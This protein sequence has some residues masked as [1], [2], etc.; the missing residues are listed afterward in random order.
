MTADVRQEWWG[1]LRHGGMLLAPALLE[2]TV[3][4][5]DPLD[6]RD[7]ERLRLAW[8]R[9]TAAAGEPSAD[10]EF[11][12]ALLESFLDLRD[13]WQKASTV[14]PAFKALATNGSALRPDWVLT[15][16][17]TQD[18]ALVLVKFDP[19][20]RLGIGRSRRAHAALVELLRATGAP[21]GLLTNGHQLRLVHA[22]P[23]YDAWAEW[24]ARRWFD[25]TEGRA[26]LQGLRA[27]IGTADRLTALIAAIRDSRSRQGELAQVLGEQV[28]QGVELVLTAADTHADPPQIIALETDPATGEALEEDEVLAALYQAGTRVVMRLV[29]V[30]YAEARELL[31][32]GNE[33]YH[34][35]YGIESLYRTLSEAARDG[36]D[37]SESRTAWRRVLSLFRLV[38]DGSPHPDLPVLAYGGQ[39]FRPGDLTS[40]DPIDR[41][42]AVVERAPV[43]DRT[44]L[45]VL[46]LLKVGRIRVRR[47]RS[48]TWV[49]GTVDFS[50]LRTEYI[51]IV[52]EGLI[53]YELRRAPED[54]PIVFL[55]VGRQPAL[56]L[57]RL[58]ALDATALKKLLEAFKKDAKKAVDAGDDTG[59][60]DADEAAD[61][62]DDTAGD[63]VAT[64]EIDIAAA[65][66]AS[67]VRTAREDALRWARDAAVATG[68]I[69][70][71]RGKNPDWEKHRR[72]LAQDASILVRTVIAP[73]RVYLVASGGLRKGSGSFYTRPALS[74]PLA[75]RTLEPLCYDRAGERLTPKRPEAILGLKVCEPAMGSGSFLIAALRYLADALARSLHHYG[76]IRADGEV[77]AA[78]TLPFGTP[79]QAKEPEELLPLPPEDDR[80]DER[81]RAVLARHIVER[82]LYGVDRNPMAVE[83]AKLS[84]W[85]ETLD[86]ELPFEFLDHKLKVGNSLV[87]CWLHLVEDYP[88]KA[89]DREDAD[90][91]TSDGSKWLKAR[92]KDAKAQ[93]PDHIRGLGGAT[94]LLDDVRIHPA[95]LVGTLRQRF[96]ALHDLPRDAREHAYRTLTSSLEYRA[97]RDAMDAWCALWFWPAGDDAIP[98]PREWGALSANA[99]DRVRTLA[100]GDRY[101]HWE[102]EFPDAFDPDRVGFDAVLGNPPWDTVQ[103]EPAEFFSNVDPFY[104][105]YSKTESSRRLLELIDDTDVASRWRRYANASAN[106]ISF[107]KGVSEP[108]AVGLGGSKAARGL[109][110]GWDDARRTRPALATRLHPF[111]HQGTGKLFTYKAFTEIAHHLAVDGGRVGL[112]LPSGLYTDRGAT[113]LRKLLLDHNRWEWLYC[114]E[115]RRLVFPIHSSYKFL[116]A[117][118][119]RGGTT[120]QLAA[121]FMRHDVSEWERPH[122]NALRLDAAEL[123]RYSPRT[124]ALME[125]RDDVD[126]NLVR[127][128]Y[129]GSFSLGDYVARQ[130][131]RFQLEFMM[132]TH[133]KLFVRRPALESDRVVE[134]GQDTRDPRV[135]ARLRL[136]GIELVY[137][138]KSFGVHNPYALGKGQKDSINRFVRTATAAEYW[139]AQSWREPRVVFRDIARS[140]DQ[141]TA[142]AAVMPRAAHA[143]PAPTLDGVNPWMCAAVLA[144]L[145]IDYLIRMKV[146]AHLN[147][148]YVET[149]PFRDWER[150]PFAEYAEDLAFRLNAVGQDFPEPAD[151]P[152]VEPK[153]RL[154]ARLV[155]DALVGDLYDLGVAD[156]AHIATRFPIYD[157]HAGEHR[158]TQLVVPVYE[159]FVTG[160]YE[161]ATSTAA[162]LAC[163]RGAAGVGFGLDELWVPSG[164]WTWANEEARQILAAA[165]DPVA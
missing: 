86:R 134:P 130:G 79:A 155:L 126:A 111:R 143:N 14:A 80:F 63:D 48:A 147:W 42:M 120:E 43:D 35:S 74:V 77:G 5:I 98:L 131:G 71:P 29:L 15:D 118:I 137:E 144:S 69:K 37:L 64:L 12:A 25:A 83:L 123:Q 119:E 20:E 22:G 107:V 117:V 156:L 158:Y 150:T 24:D 125:F 7:Y 65:A 128:L 122:P 30:L 84:L 116:A 138:G 70:M 164:G 19:S 135:R 104:R 127:H 61:E 45:D 88:I 149:L 114:F 17:A 152:L 157:K 100:D 160:G 133:D 106:L 23:D 16:P 93:L 112:L 18:G 54:D 34:A 142:I 44:T 32:A 81:L 146:S 62:T 52:Y 26:T 10:R 31:P 102:L 67:E 101:F 162:Q 6:E 139:P 49:A 36:A 73:G 90:G 141:R 163:A 103:I 129:E 50:D 165:G 55:G 3:G 99:R 47:G 33:A 82:C 124:R 91:K 11:I 145:T 159:A 78:I 140:T 60:E 21:L 2:S 1:E 38:H 57:S 58:Q 151:D 85:V 13:G 66:A 154:A 68:R 95:E 110:K 41:A 87:G 105:S 96:T 28:R 97:V 53:D 39:L 46:R 115:N 161:S 9:R 56:P 51:G 59:D 72:A 136:A 92:F 108:F 75:H 148:H 109:V 27:L 8:L 4:D 132:N 76:M 40:A 153:D 89:L 121:A 94:T 113:E